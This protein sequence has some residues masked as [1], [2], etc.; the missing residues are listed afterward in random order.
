MQTLAPASHSSQTSSCTWALRRLAVGGLLAWPLAVSSTMGRGWLCAALGASLQ[1]Q[2]TTGQR[3]G[4]PRAPGGQTSVDLA[5]CQG[6]VPP[7]MLA[8]ATA[9]TGVGCE[10]GA[11]G[12]WSLTSICPA[13]MAVCVVGRQGRM[14]DDW[15]IYCSP[16]AAFV[17]QC[18][19]RLNLYPLRDVMEEQR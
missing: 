12:L 3:A 7:A 11:S 19:F 13:V 16:G 5:M 1:S 9:H 17:G 14:R 10:P 2:T 6:T 15:K 18:A 8:A 4:A